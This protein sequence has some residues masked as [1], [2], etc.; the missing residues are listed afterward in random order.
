[1]RP[2]DRLFQT[3]QLIRG[4]RLTTAR[5]LAE[6]LERSGVQAARIAELMPP[7]PR[8]RVSQRLT[9]IEM[10]RRLA[11]GLAM[12][13]SKHWTRL[14]VRRAIRER[15]VAPYLARQAARLEREKAAQPS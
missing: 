2:A 4:R 6:R 1:M 15:I 13:R 7:Q 14:K 11:F 3:V 10:H 5:W 8:L 9:R 12:G